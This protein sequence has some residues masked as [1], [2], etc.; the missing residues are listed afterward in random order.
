MLKHW[1]GRQV[2]GSK[3][4]GCTVSSECGAL[5]CVVFVVRGDAAQRIRSEPRDGCLGM[6]LRD[7]GG[8]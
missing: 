4:S 7:M 8:L 2:I 1:D 5:F 3:F 6:K